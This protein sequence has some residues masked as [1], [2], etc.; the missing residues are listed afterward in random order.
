VFHS[1]NPSPRLDDLWQAISFREEE[2]EIAAGGTQIGIDRCLAAMP[3]IVQIE[4]ANPTSGI[5]QA[6]IID[7]NLG[8]TTFWAD[9]LR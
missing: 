8:R 6:S 2:F 4:H 9:A 1:P 5:D 7:I 3:D